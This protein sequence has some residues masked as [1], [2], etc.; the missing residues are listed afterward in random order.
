VSPTGFGGRDGNQDLPVVARRQCRGHLRIGNPQHGHAPTIR[1]TGSVWP[2]VKSARLDDRRCPHHTVGVRGRLIALM[3]ALAGFALA[4]IRSDDPASTAQRP[5]AAAEQVVDRPAPEPHAPVN[6]TAA[7]NPAATVQTVLVAESPRQR[8]PALG[9][10]TVS[11]R[12]RVVAH[13][14]DRPRVFPLLI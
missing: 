8:R 6:V 4:G 7:V 11:P 9:S 5:S 13:S 1:A 14:P 2:A 10:L 3:I 12:L